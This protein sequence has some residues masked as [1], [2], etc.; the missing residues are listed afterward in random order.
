MLKR[1]INSERISDY[2][3]NV[4]KNILFSFL[5]LFFLGIFYSFSSTS[6]LAGE[7]LIKIFIIIFQT[8]NFF[9]FGY[10]SNVLYFLYKKIFFKKI[11]YTYFCNFISIINISTYNRS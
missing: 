2:W 3:R 11:N 4:D 6:S 10:F 7:S 5:A 8:P 9:Y 1:L